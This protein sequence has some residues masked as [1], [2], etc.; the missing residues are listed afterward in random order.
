[1]QNKSKTE[2]GTTKS[3]I[4]CGSKPDWTTLAKQWSKRFSDKHKN[5]THKEFMDWLYK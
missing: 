1:M 3:S 5:E 2:S 4:E